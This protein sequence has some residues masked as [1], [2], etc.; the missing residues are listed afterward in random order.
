MTL[1]ITTSTIVIAIISII[2]IV[3][4]I[5]AYK[6]YSD[7]EADAAR[8][9][10][11]LLKAFE[12]YKCKI[13]ELED[14]R[15]SE[16]KSLNTQIEELKNN[17]SLELNSA[18]E[19]RESEIVETEELIKSRIGE[20]ENVYKSAIDDQNITLELYERYI[21]N[22]DAAITLSGKKLADLDAKG[23]FASDDEIGFF[24]NYVKDLQSVLRKT[25]IS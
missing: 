16:V 11:S 12:E 13:N 23:I 20:I 25:P 9:K 8:N 19:I 21:R 2:A 22:F 7:R 14:K 5:I 3:G 15:H 18:R 17:H 1:E 4:W 6:E 10:A 24:F